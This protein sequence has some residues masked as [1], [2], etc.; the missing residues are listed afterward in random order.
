M[1]SKVIFLNF[2]GRDEFCVIIEDEFLGRFT[3]DGSFIGQYVP[4]SM[5]Q[6]G[7]GGAAPTAGTQ[8]N[9]MATYV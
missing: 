9:T 1:L 6:L 2:R 8:P 7:P 3:E 5:R 4:S